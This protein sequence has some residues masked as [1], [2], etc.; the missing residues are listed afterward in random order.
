MVSFDSTDVDTI[1]LRKFEKG[2]NFTQLVDTLQWDRSN[3]VFTDQRDT[4]RIA[5]HVGDVLLKSG[6]DYKVVIPATNRT[7]Q[8]SEMNEPR[9]E[10]NCK[11]KLMC[12]NV[13][14]SCKLDGV[15]MPLQYETLYLRK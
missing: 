12:V 8:I 6:F 11:E 5:I 3:V 15:S 13:I 10:G 4:F 9:H 1:I 2:T 7:F 14:V